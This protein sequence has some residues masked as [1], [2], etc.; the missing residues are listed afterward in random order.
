MIKYFPDA[1]KGAADLHVNVNN[2]AYLNELN[3]T[4]YNRPSQ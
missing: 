4:P 2:I 3:L 1:G